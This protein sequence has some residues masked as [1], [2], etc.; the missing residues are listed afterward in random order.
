LPP[1]RDLPRVDRFCG[2]WQHWGERDDVLAKV[3]VVVDMV[4]G[5]YADFALSQG[6]SAPLM[7]VEADAAYVSPPP[8]SGEFLT[9]DQIRSLTGKDPSAY[10]FLMQ[11]DLDV[12][13]TLAQRYFADILVPG[14]GVA[15]QGCGTENKFGIINIWSSIPVASDVEGGL[16]MDFDHELSHMF[17]MMDNWPYRQG[18]VSPNGITYDDWIPYVMFGW[19]DADGDGIPE[20]IDPMPYGTTNP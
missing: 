18:V 19:T 10:D 11:I 2:L 6:L 20:I 16:I 17:G 12:N 4:N 8:A 15:L 3:P 14:G 5:L 7:H 9:A 13:A 1:V